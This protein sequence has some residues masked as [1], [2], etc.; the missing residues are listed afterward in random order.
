MW[1]PSS[2]DG[3][4]L[5]YNIWGYVESKACADPHPSVTALKKTVDETWAKIL[6]PDHIKKVC[7]AF[8][9]RLQK[10]ID[11]KDGTFEPRKRK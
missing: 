10:M 8:P 4:P 5:D 11:A 1:P 7:T 2:P 9:G 6:T 3:N